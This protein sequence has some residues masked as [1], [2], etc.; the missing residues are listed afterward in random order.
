MKQ[1]K[2]FWDE[3]GDKLRV[4]IEKLAKDVIKN[5]PP[6]IEDGRVED[7]R[8]KTVLLPFE[9]GDV[10]YVIDGLSIV[11][12]VVVSI[13]LNGIKDMGGGTFC[14][15]VVENACTLSFLLSDVGEFVFTMQEEALNKVQENEVT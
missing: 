1:M 6:I 2:P 15:N 10:V 8:A 14:V 9:V 11:K 5:I 13:E 7:G 3:Y 4:E 12:S